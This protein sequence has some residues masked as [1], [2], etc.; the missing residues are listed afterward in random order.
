MK[1]TQVDS[2]NSDQTTPSLFTSTYFESKEAI[3]DYTDFTNSNLKIRPTYC[4]TKKALDG[5]EPISNR[6]LSPF[7][8]TLIIQ[9]KTRTDIVY[10]TI[11]S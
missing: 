1:Q 10:R 4:L 8:K 2:T 11:C 3:L 9:L 6:S 7:K 5:E